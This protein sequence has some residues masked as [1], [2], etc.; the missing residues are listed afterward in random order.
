MHSAMDRL[1]I[2]NSFCY[3]ETVWDCLPCW[4][5]FLH[6]GY[7]RSAMSYAMAYEHE[8]LQA[9]LRLACWLFSRGMTLTFLVD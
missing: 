6:L 1:K 8:G 2:R 7:N 4:Y 3:I 9:T 5:K